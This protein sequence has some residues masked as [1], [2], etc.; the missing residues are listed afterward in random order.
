MVYRQ[1]YD[2]EQ[3]F[4]SI[5][6]RYLYSKDEIIK[7]NLWIRSRD[8]THCFC[9]IGHYTISPAPKRMFICR[10]LFFV[11][12]PTFVQECQIHSLLDYFKVYNNKVDRDIKQQLF[13]I[14]SSK[15]LT[16]GPCCVC[17]RPKMWRASGG[18]VYVMGDVSCRIGN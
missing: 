13:Y 5:F 11:L 18:P 8:C 16:D 12:L 10:T 15:R 2:F 14:T 3:L 4:I 1:S 6:Q 17:D 7:K 9:D